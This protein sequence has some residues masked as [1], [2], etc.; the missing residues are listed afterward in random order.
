[1]HIVALR[2]SEVTDFITELIPSA[3][4]HCI[5]QGLH[6]SPKIAVQMS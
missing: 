5:H 1:M 6:T 4:L 3:R 2:G